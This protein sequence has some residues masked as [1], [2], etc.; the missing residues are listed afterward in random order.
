MVNYKTHIMVN[1]GVGWDGKE[2]EA[3][4]LADSILSRLTSA[5][6]LSFKQLFSL[7]V[8]YRV[9]VAAAQ[10]KQLIRKRCLGEQQDSFT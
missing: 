9:S 6:S 10:I 2:G 4:Y 1:T 7:F 3:G 8:T 5:H